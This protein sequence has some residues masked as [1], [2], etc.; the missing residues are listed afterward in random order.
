[1]FGDA[2]T[3]KGKSENLSWIHR[4]PL[5]DKN[6]NNNN[7]FSWTPQTQCL[8]SS[9]VIMDITCDYGAVVFKLTCSLE[10]WMGENFLTPFTE[11]TNLL[12]RAL[13]VKKT[14]NNTII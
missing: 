14:K 8:V 13:V 9:R 4:G 11:G 2:A 5:V 10:I 6:N 1:M 12:K 3:V 7:N